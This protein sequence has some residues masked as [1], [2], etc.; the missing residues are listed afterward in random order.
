MGMKE[1][2]EMLGL[3]VDSEQNAVSGI[4]HAANKDAKKIALRNYANG[5]NINLDEA[6]I[7]ALAECDYEWVEGGRNK[8]TVSSPRN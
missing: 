2:H 6:D 7:D 1:F 3:I 4:L 8:V 5:K